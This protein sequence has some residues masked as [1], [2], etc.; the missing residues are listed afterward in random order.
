V[1]ICGFCNVLMCVYLCFIMCGCVYLWFLYCVLVLVMCVIVFTVFCIVFTVFL[2]CF[3]DVYV[4]L[5]VL[6]VLPASDKSIA[7]N[8]NNNNNN[9]NNTPAPQS[10]NIPS[11]GIRSEA[12]FIGN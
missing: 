3:V 12:D 11:I 10:R 6:T 4:F 7:V 9:N 2:Y 8:N 5:L 1:C